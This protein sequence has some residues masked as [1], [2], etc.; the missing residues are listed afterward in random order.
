[1]SVA[2]TPLILLISPDSAATAPNG[3]RSEASAVRRTE[4]EAFVYR[5][6]QDGV[7]RRTNRRGRN[8]TGSQE[9]LDPGPGSGP[10]RP[11]SG[12][13][14]SRDGGSP[15]K[16]RPT[17]RALGRVGR[18][19]HLTFVG[20]KRVERCRILRPRVPIADGPATGGLSKP[21]L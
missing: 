10:R 11:S 8:R 13:R 6:P 12:I 5:Q 19:D 20:K 7:D 16:S 3:W 1:M 9:I 18:K 17:L 14:L 4:K 2:A 15:A 21:F